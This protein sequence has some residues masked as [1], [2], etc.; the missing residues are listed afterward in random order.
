MRGGEAYDILKFPSAVYFFGRPLFFFTV[1]TDEN[2]AATTA[3][4][5][6]IVVVKAK[7]KP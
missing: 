7:F 3:G 1:V 4:A 6:V 5:T 2:A